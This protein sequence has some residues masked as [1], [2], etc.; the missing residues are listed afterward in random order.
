M[1]QRY[2]QTLWRYQI[3]QSLS[4]KGNCWGNSPMRR[5]FRSLKTEW[6]PASGYR[7]LDEA[8]QSIVGH[9]IKCYSIMRPYQCSGDFSRLRQE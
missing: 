8:W 6:V 5:F 1:N 9:L 7:S 4:Q 2:R 3:K